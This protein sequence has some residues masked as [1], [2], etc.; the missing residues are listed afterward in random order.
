MGY[1]ERYEKKTESILKLLSQKK[2]FAFVCHLCRLAYPKLP[3]I[4]ERLNID[5]IME[6]EEER[7]DR[8]VTYKI[9]ERFRFNKCKGSTIDAVLFVLP[10][11]HCLQQDAC[12]TVGMMVKKGSLAKACG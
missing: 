3:P 5:F 8:Y 1:Q 7:R 9:L 4:S 12:L 10:A 6:R 11:Y 2:M